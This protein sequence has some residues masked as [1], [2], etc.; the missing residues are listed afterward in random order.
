MCE[1]LRSDATVLLKSGAN[2]GRFFDG[3]KQAQP[4]A[5]RKSSGVSVGLGDERRELRKLRPAIHRIDC[6][7]IPVYIYIY[8]FIY[9]YIYI[10]FF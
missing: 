6:G 8:I 10:F 2:V 4:V 9:I 1:Q 5:H 3:R 7:G